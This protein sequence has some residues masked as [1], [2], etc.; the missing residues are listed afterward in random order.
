M[1]DQDTVPTDG[2]SS[3]PIHFSKDSKNKE[4][5]QAQQG[6]GINIVLSLQK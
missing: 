3:T 1:T 2:T 6:S 4:S 5:L